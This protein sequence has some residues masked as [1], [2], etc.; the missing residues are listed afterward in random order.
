M[1]PTVT[2]FIIVA[3]ITSL[4]GPSR[5]NASVL[6]K[7]SNQPPVVAALDEPTP[8]PT[9][10]LEEAYP[11]PPPGG[12][13][14][15]T[16]DPTPTA[17]ATEIPIEKLPPQPTATETP[18]VEP[19]P[20]PTATE[21][22]E[23]EVDLHCRV[24]DERVN[25][26]V[27]AEPAIY[28]PGKPIKISW[29]IC[30][31]A[32]I[33]DA[34][35]E[36]VF[37]IPTGVAP[38]KSSLKDQ[39]TSDQTL[40]LSSKPGEDKVSWDITETASFPMYFSIRLQVDGKEIDTQT[41]QIDA[42]IGEASREK[43]NRIS[44]A[45]G[46][47]QIEV[48]AEA[49]DEDLLFS[50]R[51]PSPHKLP[52]V[53]LTGAPLEIIAVDKEAG[54]KVDHFNSPIAIQVSYD[55]NLLF[56]GSEDDLLLFYYNEE[57]SDWY[58]L[59]TTVD[60]ETQRLTAYSDHLTVFDYKAASWQG[61]VPPSV[62]AF[63]VSG[64][65]GAATYDMDF[66]VLPGPGGLKPVVKLSYNS[67]VIDEGSAFTQAS[68]VGMGWSLDT[69][70][71]T[72][73]MHETNDDVSDDTFMISANGI[74][75]QLL[76]VAVNGS[77]TTY[78]TANQTYTK[79]QFDS[80]VNAWK[81]WGKDGTIY[82]FAYTAKTS[83]NACETN[84]SGLN[85]TWQWS[86]TSIT[87]IF[88][89]TITY[90]Y[91]P[92][93]KSGCQN[94]VAVYPKTI[95][96]AGGNYQIEFVTEARA[97]YK[98][99][100][101]QPANKAFYS[102]K[103]L[104]ELKFQHKEGSNWVT[105]RKFVFSYAPNTGSEN[106]ILPNFKWNDATNTLTLISVQE[107]NG[108]GSISLPATLFY[109]NVDQMHLNKVESGYGGKVE[110]I[111]G[112]INQFDDA[113]KSARF[114]TWR[115]G[116]NECNPNGAGID[117]SWDQEGG[118]VRCE[119][120]VGEP[121]YL[122]LEGSGP[123]AIQS[124][125][126]H[127]V[128]PGADYQ[129]AIRGMSTGSD[130][131]GTYWGFKD[132]T[133]PGRYIRLND[134]NNPPEIIQ[135]YLNTEWTE[136]SGTLSMPSN[137]NPTNIYLRLEN[138]GS[139]ISLLEVALNITRY[140]VSS[141]TV[142]D[143]VTG[144]TSTY[145]YDYDNAAYNNAVTSQSVAAGGSLYA[146]KMGEFRGHALTQVT[147]PVGLTAMTWNAQSDALKGTAFH[148]VQMQQTFADG[149]DEGTAD[150]SQ[151][152]LTPPAARVNDIYGEDL[153]KALY[154]YDT[155]SSPTPSLSRASY[156]LSGG[157]AF[158][159]QIRL[160]KRKPFMEN[161]DSGLQH[162]PISGTA[163]A[164]I[165]I[166]AQSGKFFGIHVTESGVGVGTAKLR[167]NTGAGL[168]DGANLLPDGQFKLGRWYTLLV[169]VDPEDGFLARLWSMDDPNSFG[170]QR[171]SGFASET[172]R[173]EEKVK[174]GS[175]WL[176]A[177]AEGQVF[178]ES[179]TRYQVDLQYCMEGGA[180]PCGAQTG[181]TYAAIANSRLND[182][183][184]LKIYWTAPIE[185]VERSYMVNPEEGL[186]DSRWMGTRTTYEYEMAY[187]NNRQFGNLTRA[188]LFTWNGS[189]WVG[190]KS[191][192]TR[193]WPLDEIDRYLTALPASQEEYLCTDTSC[194][195]N[196][197][198]LSG[199]TRFLY[200][201]QTNYAAAPQD[202]KLTGKRSLLRVEGT[203]E[204]YSDELYAY[205]S[206]GNRIWVKR[207]TGEGT[208]TAL[209]TSGEQ[210]AETCYGVANQPAGCQAQPNGDVAYPLWEKL[211]LSPTVSLL[212]SWEYDYGLGVPTSETDPNGAVTYAI[213]DAFGRI[214][215][216]IRPGDF[217]SSPTMSFVY[218]DTAPFWTEVTQKTASSPRS[219]IR[220]FYNGLGDLIQTQST[221]QVLADGACSNTTDGLPD[222][223]DV[224]VDSW[225]G[226][227]NQPNGLR[228]VTKQTAPYAVPAGTAGYLGTPPA[229]KQ[230]WT[231]AVS[232]VLGRTV[233]TTNPDGTQTTFQYG[234]ET[235]LVLER[236][237]A[238]KDRTVE[239]WLAYTEQTQIVT[240]NLTSAPQVTRTY[241][242][243]LGN[244]VWVKSALS[245]YVYY[246]YDT[247][248]RLLHARL[249]DGLTTTTEN[250]VVYATGSS[251]D[252]TYDLAGR[253]QSLDDADM[254][255]WT[256]AYRCNGKSSR[257]NKD[258]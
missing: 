181:D 244:T 28:L 227:E 95:V 113:N 137:Y 157:E 39:V 133:V 217:S 169:I 200:D 6:V 118:I 16:P 153:D 112:K 257:S 99:S 76:P 62:D 44:S 23:T 168:Q 97:D 182:F 90:S 29:K 241:T 141:R 235:A 25:L 191:T 110:F 70:A 4:V 58:P 43:N 148:T 225:S 119:F 38:S 180:S 78:N 69:G 183:Y 49:V 221:N 109:Y 92:G 144:K 154:L 226:F 136:I 162:L 120:P 17:T 223:C 52:P 132:E 246:Q 79:V 30:G 194:S 211:V 42:G 98:Q 57:V 231:S 111:Y 10:T 245:P 254:G 129:F 93:I 214:R 247:S 104:R 80:S 27:D 22:P 107:Q 216:L 145:T 156:L 61:Y 173:Y 13:I 258:L 32:Q 167:Y 9:P 36:I 81:A 50:A 127:L 151:W 236:D 75:G 233:A 195:P 131:T 155:D 199:A 143:E 213:Y 146:Y 239:Q 8:T 108:D 184:D 71:I 68:W 174:N 15:A 205:D 3:L 19:E 242:N 122:L 85:L 55:K 128:K 51:K 66:P 121:G 53:S 37:T 197:L 209:A 220:K 56:G 135:I 67:Q 82:Q 105:T 172:W 21:T 64:F 171:F 2:L 238:G 101:T 7:R 256:Y 190:E 208:A 46:R 234:I 228:Q 130:G 248:G 123:I 94:V 253:K 48:P 170:E 88:G 86:L 1:N 218:H 24:S 40:I 161:T 100:W 63:Q 72:R 202:G 103:R 229:G 115:F 178:T 207:Y 210:I 164:E 185:S 222:H 83:G 212:T 251:T 176:D 125:P 255:L 232:D 5:V 230:F 20:Q 189:G 126:Q 206:K 147:D 237:S 175:L 124:F 117:T 198:E 138:G 116:D 45:D 160:D 187:Q 74:S 114:S 186:G 252:I 243:A 60:K 165:G 159:A 139:R 163:E 249:W 166:K 47:V 149:F 102:T 203:Q 204:Y 84:V 54:V 215:S 35:A 177:Y 14:P 96:Y 65:T 33:K 34:E 219:A 193:Y 73:N 140:R 179:F 142:T 150:V 134:P 12:E 152:S 89:N 31:Y 240:R 26:K 224:V 18:A 250:G 192:R 91:D 106:V 59:P 11:Y 41:I 201:G 77:I 87:D 188:T 158:I 196:A